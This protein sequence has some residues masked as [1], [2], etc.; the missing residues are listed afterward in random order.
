MG[1]Q[2][3]W[4]LLLLLIV[5]IVLSY[6]NQ[7][8]ILLSD[9]YLYA[10]NSFLLAGQQFTLSSSAFDN[11]FGVTLPTALLVKLF[12]IHYYL[13]TLW[14]L[15]SFLALLAATWFLVKKH[16]PELAF[17]ATLFFVIN[18][19]FLKLSADLLPDMIMAAWAT[20]A[21]YIL[22]D[23]RQDSLSGKKSMLSA[24]A[25]VLC[26][27]IAA[28]SKET[29]VFL[30]PFVLALI[31]SDAM[32]KRNYSFWIATTIFSGICILGYFGFYQIYTGDIF[33]R[34]KGIETE[35]NLSEIWSY[36]DKPGV[37]ILKRL[38]IGPVLFLLTSP[39]Y[40]FVT[41][42][43][44]ATIVLPGRRQNYFITFWT[45]YLAF[46]I[47]IHWFGST[48]LHSYNPLPLYP[49]MW[50]LA[51]PP[52]CLLSS[53]WIA[54]FQQ[55]QRRKLWLILNGIILFIIS[56]QLLLAQDI[57]IVFGWFFAAIIFTYVLLKK[58]QFKPYFVASVL[59]AV[60]GLQL[61]LFAGYRNDQTSFYDEAKLF[62]KL[63]ALNEDL[64]IVADPP[65]ARCYDIYFKFSPPSQL[66]VINWDSLQGG[67]PGGRTEN[68]YLWYNANRMKELQQRYERKIP[69]YV[70]SIV[71]TS[72]PVF[73]TGNVK[74][75][76][77]D[78]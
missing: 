59:A 30:L 65:L 48:S 37:E 3:H 1:H 15:F 14:P 25:F 68:Y 7:Q 60:L 9:Q 77:V 50:I 41:I 39:Y 6:A 72:V 34:L 28:L 76:A 47:A 23:A 55:L 27:F 32:Q 43:S 38:T 29:V 64:T 20:I 46:I 18:P 52:L 13:L 75:Y 26:L 10:K 36:H 19:L 24:L 5:A 70:N 2:G 71:T 56:V 8:G 40:T 35:H 17:A 11:R 53:Y 69:A 31:I 51:M 57:K 61:A 16:Q 63:G 54:Y 12:G 44:L 45:L 66:E 62:N 58:P 73:D 21:V 67:L 33:Y 4:S 49:R 78:F 42:L 74:I 22:Y